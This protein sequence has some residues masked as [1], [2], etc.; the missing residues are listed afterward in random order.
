MS[1]GCSVCFQ[2]MRS[3]G[4]ADSS[5][6]P[7]SLSWG[8]K[9]PSHM[10]LSWR[11]PQVQKALILLKDFTALSTPTCDHNPEVFPHLHIAGEHPMLSS[12]PLREGQWFAFVGRAMGVCT[13]VISEP[14]VSQPTHRLWMAL[15]RT[16]GW[17]HPGEIKGLS[18]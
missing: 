9:L 10:M 12:E 17:W 13:M 3:V 18:C 5:G 16:S 6:M 14:R 2:S 1:V 11:C 8:I 7:F 4:L 15:E